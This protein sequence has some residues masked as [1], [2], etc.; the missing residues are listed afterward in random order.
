[1]ASLWKMLTQAWRGKA[2]RGGWEKGGWR[3]FPLD[4]EPLVA[5]VK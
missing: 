5:E 4:L 2:L 1:M 3:W